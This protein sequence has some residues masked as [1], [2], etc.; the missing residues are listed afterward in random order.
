MLG[1]A[2]VVVEVVD[3]VEVGAVGTVEFDEVE[4]SK[5]S[6][7]TIL[8][9]GPLPLIF[10]SSIPFSEAIFL[11]RGEALIRPLDAIGATCAACGVE[12]CG[13]ALC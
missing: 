7:L 4:P 5:R 8:P 12:F 10:E 13:V 1:V 2:E 6:F 3:G 9:S 11:A